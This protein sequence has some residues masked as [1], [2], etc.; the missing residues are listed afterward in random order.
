M[1]I[2][3]DKDT[4]WLDAVIAF[5]E[6]PI[7]FCKMSIKNCRFAFITSL[8]WKSVCNKIPFREFCAIQPEFIVKPLFLILRNFAAEF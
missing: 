6:L 3:R 5:T 8:P 7:R 4:F 2:G 1:L